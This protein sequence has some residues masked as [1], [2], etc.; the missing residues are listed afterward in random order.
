MVGGLKTKKD[1]VTIAL[2][3]FIQRRETEQLIAAFGTI[4]FDERYDYKAERNRHV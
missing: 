2:K 1:T 3:E 4:D